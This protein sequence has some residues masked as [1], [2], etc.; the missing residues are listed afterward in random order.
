MRH[1]ALGLLLLCALQAPQAW[2]QDLEVLHWWTSGGEAQ[3]VG[4]L[5]KI[6]KEKSGATWKDFTV[7]G[8]GGEN[9][10]KVLKT[11]ALAGHPP[12]AVQ[13]KGPQVQDWGKLGLLTDINEIAKRERWDEKLPREIANTAKYKNNWVAVPFNVHRINWVWINP[14]VLAQAKAKVPTTLNE[15]FE[16]ADKIKKIGILPFAHGGQAWQDATVFEELLLAVAGP[17]LYRKALV[18]HDPKALQSAPMKATFDA[19]RKYSSYLDKNRKGLD[20]DKATRLVMDGTAGMQFMGDWAK[21]EFIAAGKRPGQDF[22]CI[23]VPGSEDSFIY[24]V[25]SFA[26][27]ETKSKDTKKN[28][29]QLAAIIMDETFQKTFNLKKGSIPALPT[30]SMDDFDSCAKASMESFKK[31]SKGNGQVPSLAHQM[32]SSSEVMNAVS[33]LVEAY[34]N[35]NMSSDEA[36]KRLAQS[37]REAT[38]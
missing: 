24:N 12:A 11:K 18:D 38:L 28:Q 4:V 27:F 36:V 30:T 7:A 29:E 22:L 10:L 14:Q 5:K 16:T 3:S 8:G 33:E 15:L 21:G 23:P 6:F 32:A 25:D 19:L 17:D 1:P 9:A 26:F 34:I 37:I 13:M 31:T 20:W 35:S 2:A